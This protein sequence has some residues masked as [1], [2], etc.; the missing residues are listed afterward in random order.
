[1][2]YCPVSSCLH[3]IV[4]RQ[5]QISFFY[6]VRTSDGPSTAVP[7]PSPHPS[8]SSSPH[9]LSGLT[10]WWFSRSLCL[11]SALPT[12][13]LPVQGGLE[14]PAPSP[15]NGGTHQLSRS[16]IRDPDPDSSLSHTASRIW[17]LDLAPDYNAINQGPDLEKGPVKVTEHHPGS[18]RYPRLRDERRATETPGR[19][20]W[21]GPL[22]TPVLPQKLDS[23]GSQRLPYGRFCFQGVCLFPL[24]FP[25][26]R[27][28]SDSDFPPAAA[29]L[30]PDQRL[31]VLPHKRGEQLSDSKQLRKYDQGTS[32][33]FQSRRL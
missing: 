30:T 10:L 20:A 29:P 16:R 18:G 31:F 17:N 15:A 27:F 14:E 9:P 7:E 3:S 4:T 23:F 21:T 12:Q 2:F 19:S 25:N 33:P 24:L 32:Q 22:Q 1:M 13:D 8:I 11:P 28:T 5:E 6:E 26:R